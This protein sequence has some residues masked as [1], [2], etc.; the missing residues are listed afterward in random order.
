MNEIWLAPPFQGCGSGY[1]M[2]LVLAC[3]VCAGFVVSV[4]PRVLVLVA[5]G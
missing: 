1:S 2:D 5:F 4:Q 3:C